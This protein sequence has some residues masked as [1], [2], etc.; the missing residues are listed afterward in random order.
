MTRHPLGDVNVSAAFQIVR[1][2]DGPER[3]IAYGRL[4]ARIPRPSAH[5]VPCIDAG[6]RPLGQLARPADGG[7]KQ[8]TFL[9]LGD[10][11]R[12]DIF[13]QILLKLMVAS[14]EQVCFPLAEQAALL[15]RQTEG[16]KDELVALITSAEPSRL[17]AINWLGLNRDHWGVESLHQRLDISHNDD[18]C[19]VRND[20]AMLVLGMMLR[21]SN[22][23]FM[24][25]RGYQRRP[26]HVTTTDFQS[27]LS[28]DQHRP[29]LRLAV[30]KHP[31]LKRLS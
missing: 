8:R 13:I 16:R 18:R 12:R 28:E 21:L 31:D 23:L 29:A 6:H 2:A 26:D 27:S 19:R 24:Q 4:D 20:N 14:A 3:M 11:C 17:N 15:L 25:W 22:S 30:H 10:P 9:V 7:A 1:D 5:H